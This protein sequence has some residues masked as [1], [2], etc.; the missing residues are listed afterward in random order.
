M[1]QLRLILVPNGTNGLSMNRPLESLG[2]QTLV[3]TAGIIIG[4]V[5]SFVML[6]LY[7]RYLTPADYGVLELL[8]MTIE[9]IGMITG[10]GLVTGVFK[11]YCAEDEPA[12]KNAIMSTAA[13]GVLALAVGT[14]GLGLLLANPISKVVFGSEVNAPYLRLYFVLFFL[15]NFEWVPLLLIR[16]EKRA[17]LFVTVNAI[18]LAVVLSLNILFVVFF[19]M[20]VRG[21]LI[22][23]IIT[24]SL[25]AT[26]LTWYL[27]REVGI[28]FK[29]R[30]FRQM[31]RFGGPIVPWS[32]A[33]FALVFSDRFF[34]N[35]YTDTSTVGIYS[36]AYKFA[37]LVSAFAVVPFYNTWDIQR[38]EVAKRPDAM[39]MYAR[40]FL[41]LNVLVGLVGLGVCLFARDV[42]VIMSDRAFLPAYRMVPLLIAAQIVFTWGAFWNLGLYISG[43]TKAMAHGSVVLVPVTLLINYLL[44]PKFGIYGA[45]WA[46]FVAYTFRFWWIYYF[47]QR[48]YPIHYRWEELA[49]L[50]GILGAA[51]LIRF[52]YHPPN[53]FAS[54]GWGL[55]LML[56]ATALVYRL[57]SDGDRAALSE[58]VRRYLPSRTG[59]RARPAA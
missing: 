26:G 39:E 27:V 58:M 13:L 24:G 47:A 23:G 40:V 30:W 16:A 17:V 44:I 57:L 37:F 15:Q 9:V 48:H 33:S 19:R 32:L 34:L 31:V 42:L 36:L 41:Y 11:F 55:V 35:H 10:V 21:V 53:V 18:R 25:M 51:I 7:T 38:F 56:V 49:K 45:A 3:Y 59:V 43:E 6:P 2:K 8:S 22:S 52:S 50:Y 54:I 28:G 20:G 5:A 1:R 4:K 12:E 29:V 14:A 46:T